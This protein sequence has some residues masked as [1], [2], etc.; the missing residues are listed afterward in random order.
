MEPRLSYAT[1]LGLFSQVED[2]LGYVAPERPRGYRCHLRTFLAEQDRDWKTEGA[3][4]PV[5]NNYARSA[6]GD[7]IFVLLRGKLAPPVH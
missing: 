3:I 1:F 6:P 5:E 2:P 7:S 4:P